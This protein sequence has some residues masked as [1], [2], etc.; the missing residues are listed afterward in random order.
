MCFKTSEIRFLYYNVLHCLC[1]VQCLLVYTYLFVFFNPP[2]PDKV[3][4]FENELCK[5]FSVLMLACRNIQ[6]LTSFVQCCYLIEMVSV[7]FWYRKCSVEVLPHKSVFRSA[8]A[9]L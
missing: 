6:C 9:E 1:V 5:P 4:V 2:P 7:Y 3:L 8:S